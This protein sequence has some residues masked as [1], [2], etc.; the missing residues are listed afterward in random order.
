[1]EPG[2][3]LPTQPNRPNVG[4]IA[5]RECGPR[6]EKSTLFLGMT[7]TTRRCCGTATEAPG[8]EHDQM[9]TFFVNSALP[10]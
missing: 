8:N 6:I 10:T 5:D 7:T 3:D 2:W 4:T 9:S 1:V